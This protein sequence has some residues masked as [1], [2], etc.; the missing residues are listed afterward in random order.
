MIHLT[1]EQVSS[2]IDELAAKTSVIAPCTQDGITR[3]QRINRSAEIDWQAARPL[4]PAKALFFPQTER[5]LEIERQS[6]GRQTRLRETYSDEDMVL[7]GV[8]PCDARGLRAL[9]AVFIET[10]PV[11]AHYSRRRARAT[12][13]GLACPALGPTCFCTSVGLAPDEPGDV[14]LM[15]S[16]ADDGYMACPITPAGEALLAGLDGGQPHP[17]QPFP[18]QPCCPPPEPQAWQTV[19]HHPVWET[20]SERCL[21]CRLCAYLC[22]ACRCFDIRDETQAAPD[23]HLV[24]ER[25]RCWDSCTSPRYRRIAG[26]HDSR[27]EAAQRL[28]NRL[29]CKFDYFPLQY[30][31]LGCTGCG[32][33]VEHCPAGIDLREVL[34]LVARSGAQEGA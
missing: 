22:P 18:A 3:F 11:D 5:L 14:D 7:V 33:C 2:L 24:S 1:C 6:A 27:P 16:Q 25:L 15:L 13:I 32:R 4:L 31:A 17:R 29:M 34:D 30:G 12:L 21:S 8:R 28:R 26:G 20:F 9:D 10:D 19:F 23:G